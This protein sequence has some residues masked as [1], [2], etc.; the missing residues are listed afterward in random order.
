[1]ETKAIKPYCFFGSAKVKIG[2]GTFVNYRCFFDGFET[3]EIGSECAIAYGVTFCTSAH[4]I[5]PGWKRASKTIGAPIRVG[6]GCWI[7]ANVTILPGVHI[8]DGCIVAAG[9]VVD[10]DCDPNGLYAGVPARR[11]KDLP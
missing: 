6:N 4:E 2:R 1:M 9:A 11:I 8:G 7:G 5:G 3:I 10:K